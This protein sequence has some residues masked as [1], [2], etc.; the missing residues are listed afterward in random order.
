MFGICF[1][2]LFLDHYQSQTINLR[3][4]AMHKSQLQPGTTMT[5]NKFDHVLLFMS[6]ARCE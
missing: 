1:L 3:G 2:L 6:L 5:R 4:D